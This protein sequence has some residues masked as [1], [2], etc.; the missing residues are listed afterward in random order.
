[1]ELQ[2]RGQQR[3]RRKGR[4]ARRATRSLLHWIDSTKKTLGHLT[5]P[6]LRGNSRRDNVVLAPL[7]RWK[8][9]TTGPNADHK[10]PRVSSYIE[11]RQPLEDHLNHRANC[12]QLK[13]QHECRRH[14]RHYAKGYQSS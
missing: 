2:P 1:M 8:Y 13:M 3:H 12:L 6:S 10:A 5:L 14:L 9:Q 7:Q 11:H 4:D